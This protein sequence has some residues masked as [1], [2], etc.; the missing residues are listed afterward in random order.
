M[1]LIEASA[2]NI[3][4]VGGRTPYSGRLEV[5][6]GGQWGTVCDDEFTVTS[7]KVVCRMLGFEDTGHWDKIVLLDS[8]NCNGYEEDVAN[9]SHDSWQSTDCSHKEDV[10]VNCH[11]KVQLATGSA[12]HDG[13]VE[14]NISG[15]WE[16]ICAENFTLSEAKVVCGMMGFSFNGAQLTSSHS[17]RNTFSPISYSC[18][19][20]EKDIYLCVRRNTSTCFLSSAASINC[21]TPIWL[22]NGTSSQSGRVEVEYRGRWGT[23]CDDGFDDLEAKVICN[24]LGFSTN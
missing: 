13:Q 24:M 2:T 1:A 22:V 14:V 5:E 21:R 11:T 8:L 7:A 12:T 16:P 6:H 18:H 9:C 3:R 4:L 15:I 17:Y 23:I 19:G 10:G 20:A